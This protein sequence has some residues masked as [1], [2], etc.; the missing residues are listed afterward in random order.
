MAASDQTLSDFFEVLR[1]R[2]WTLIIPFLAISA[3]AA[4][5]ALAL[6]PVYKS[7]S[8]ILIEQQ[9]IPADFVQT[10]VTTY[11]EQ[12]LQIINQRIMT[13]TKLLEIMDKFSLYT[14]LR[15]V[16]TTEEVVDKMRSDISMDPIS[17]DV[18]DRKTGRPTTATIAF[19][20][21]YAG[22]N[23]PEKVQQVAN[24]LT[25]L[26]LEE[27]VKVRERQAS[28][29]SRFLE[30]EMVRVKKELTVID[31]KLA[32]FKES[33]VNELPELLQ[34]SMQSLNNL[35]QQKEILYERLMNTKERESA[36]QAQLA[37]ISPGSEE[38]DRRRLDELRVRLVSLKERFSSKY[39]DV[40][41]TEAE[42]RELEKKVES[43]AGQRGTNTAMPDN[44][45]Y[46][47]VATQLAAASSDV[48]SL[49]AQLSAIEDNIRQYRRRIESTPRVEADYRALLTERNN[50]QVKYEDLMRKHME[51]RISQGLE[52]EQKGERFTLIEPARLPEKPFKPNRFAIMLIGIVLGLGTGTASAAMKELMD[53]SIR[54]IGEIRTISPYPVLATIPVIFN[55]TEIGR[56]NRIKK[57]ILAGAA[58]GIVVVLIVFHF[59][60]MDLTIFWVKL[61]T[62]MGW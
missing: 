46:I 12:Q 9:D 50:T 21:S 36:L 56:T 4:I 35:E 60:I 14:D 15:D 32:A 48:A 57:L 62:R 16:K 25:S 3:V 27:N 5:I 61:M 51:A 26:F 52:K 7:T 10:T 6:P 59:F 33:H 41:N 37:G 47:T 17:V 20:V 38:Q 34:V 42:I 54:T 31:A 23:N 19:T 40:K 58:S 2:R 43:R 11:A 8:T 44:P 13:A 28:E 45:S 39:P 55:G 49:Q 22:K 29:I 1:R 24:V 18:V 30:D 53:D